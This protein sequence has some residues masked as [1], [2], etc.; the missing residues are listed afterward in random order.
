MRYGALAVSIC[1]I[2]SSLHSAA[3]Q[4]D[5]LLAD[6]T[7]P[8]VISYALKQQPVVQQ[9]QIDE[10]I[11][12]M[13][14]KS[15]L[16]DWFPQVNFN[17]LYQH[18][19]QVQTNIIGMGFHN[20]S[21]LQFGA[22][23]AIF[24]R[25][26]LLAKRT[27]SMVRQQAQQQTAGTKIDVVANVS[28]AFYDVLATEQQIKVTDENITRL[29]K[30]LNDAKNQYDAGVVDKTD[31]KRATIALNNALAARKSNEEVLKAKKAYLKQLMNYPVSAD[32]NIIYDSAT[33]EGE[34]AVDTVQG[35]DYSKRIEYR[36]LET[37]RSLQ[38]ANVQYNKWAYIPSLSA[39]GAYNLNYLNNSF[40]KLYNTSYPNSYAGL[41]LSFPIFQGGK[42]HYNIKQAEWEL[43]RTDLD[44]VN[45]KNEVNSEYSAALANYKANLANYLAVKENVELAKEVY[46]VIQLQ[47][48]S[49]VKTYLEVITAE[50]DLRTAQINYFDALYG[51]LSSKIDVQKSL[52]QINP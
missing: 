33:L 10:R 30:S 14:V 29:Q 23:Q 51:V 40:G 15:K 39:N 13:Q 37:Q 24:N 38:E 41:T 46:E 11:T 28:K 8:N 36:I 6:A 17:Y 50:T 26:V 5:S 42:R 12:D 4:Q 47:Y 20:T 27:G 48:R 7:L 45:L 18:N 44:I 9:A 49:G 19:F 43:K 34:I 21:A 2:F 32:L 25:D 22:S 35:A 52:G 31:Y 1:F 16:A 3:Q